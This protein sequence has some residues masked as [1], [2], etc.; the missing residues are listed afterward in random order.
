MPDSTPG[1]EAVPGSNQGNAPTRYD[2]SLISHL[3]DQMLSFEWCRE[4]LVVPLRRKENNEGSGQCI[5]IGIANYS[6]L[7]T[8]GDFIKKRAIKFGYSTQ[9]EELDQGEIE[10]LIKQALIESEQSLDRQAP[11]PSPPAPPGHL[12]A[13]QG[14]SS[15]YRLSASS[16]DDQTKEDE[17][18]IR[19][20]FCGEMILS[21]AKK[22]KHCGEYIDPVLLKA[23][24]INESRAPQERNYATPVYSI[25]GS[26]AR[27]GR[28]SGILMV[29][30]LSLEK[31]E[32]AFREDEYS[33]LEDELKAEL[34]TRYSELKNRTGIDH[35]VS[36]RNRKDKTVAT[37]LCFFLGGLG[38]HNFYIGKTGWGL[39]YLLFCWTYIPTVVSLVEVIVYLC[40]SDSEWQKKYVLS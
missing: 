12:P 1:Q 25:C 37:L 4:N 23:L 28:T 33:I 31:V 9:F 13:E 5:S 8:I 11:L 40:M 34:A 39:I 2:L 35:S 27:L 10:E 16:R 30:E 29:R 38:A 15:S 26:I 20:S 36:I 6:Y 14:T 21:I 3:I 17:K 24:N 32:L 19:C 18:T 22:C 7:A